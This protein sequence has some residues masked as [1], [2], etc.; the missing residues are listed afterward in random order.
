MENV[1]RL[2]RMVGSDVHGKSISVAVSDSDGSVT[3]VGKVD[4]TVTALRLS[5]T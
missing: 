5:I 1:A 4:G 3:F 2:A